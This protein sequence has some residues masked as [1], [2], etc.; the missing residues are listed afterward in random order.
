ML[1]DLRVQSKIQCCDPIELR[2]ANCRPIG[3]VIA[4]GSHH[5]VCLQG[6]A[7]EVNVVLVF[8]DVPDFC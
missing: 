5:W 3:H 7:N 2:W 6:L 8:Q 1:H 4:Y